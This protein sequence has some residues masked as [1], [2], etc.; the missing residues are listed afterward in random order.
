MN[1]NTNV[2]KNMKK[3]ELLL[4]CAKLNIIGY[5]SKSKAKLIE[6]CIKQENM[7]QTNDIC[8]DI[9]NRITNEICYTTINALKDE[10]LLDE[11][12]ECESVKKRVI[13]LKKIFDNNSIDQEKSN[14]MLK[15]YM[16]ELIPPGTKGVIRGNKFNKIIKNYIMSMNLDTSRFKVMFETV[17]SSCVTSEKPDWYIF[18]KATK[19]VI[20]GMNQLDLWGGGQQLNRGAKYIYNDK[21]DNKHHKLLCVVCNEIQFSSNKNK[22]FSLFEK[23]FENNTLCYLNNIGN[24]ITSFFK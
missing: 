21:Y 12:Q 10:N 15:E 24:V 17:C 3:S 18:E 16:L 5:K 22:A 13:G 7:N 2:Y 14:K 11:Y 19:K 4:A 9:N 23:G 8:A 6:M 1:T 20:I